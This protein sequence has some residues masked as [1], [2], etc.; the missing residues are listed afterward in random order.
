MFRSLPKSTKLNVYMI[1]EFVMQVKKQDISVEISCG[2]AK[3]NVS[4]LKQEGSIPLE[5]TGG[6]P[7]S[8]ITINPK[9]VHATR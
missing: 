1:F 4:T 3:L 7:F 9:D 6:S 2:Y 8:E 5:I